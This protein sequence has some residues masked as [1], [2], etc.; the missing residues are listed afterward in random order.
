MKNQTSILLGANSE[1]AKAIASEL[2]KVD[3]NQLVI[4]GRQLSFYKHQRFT[5]AKLF[6]VSNYQEESVQKVVNNIAQEE[7]LPDITRVFCCHGIL[8]SEVIF[9]EKKL[10]DFSA[11]AFSEILHANTTTPMLWLKYLFPLLPKDSLSTW[12]TFSA[13]VGSISDNRLGGWYSYRASKAALNM[14]LKTAAVEIGRR[15]KQ[16]KLISFHPGTT[17]T[18]LSKPFQANVP[19]GQL[20]TPQFVA[21]QLLS[22]LEHI[23][24]DGQLSYIDWQGQKID[25]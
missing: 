6:E 2:V 8:H 7:G 17:D 15:N 19:A 1:I 22:I 24:H 23:Q 13:R 12:V 20:F 11:D 16:V 18:P 5:G 25:W 9:P 21:N 10:E 4:V 14:L 3:D